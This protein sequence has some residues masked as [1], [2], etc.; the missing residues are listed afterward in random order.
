VNFIGLGI[1]SLTYEIFGSSV[2]GGLFF[3]GEAPSIQI[4]IRPPKVG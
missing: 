3:G 2:D 1:N 4:L